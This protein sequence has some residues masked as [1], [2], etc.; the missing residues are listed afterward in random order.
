MDKKPLRQG[1]GSKPGDNRRGIK[2][3]GFIALIVL[4]GLIIFAAYNQPSNLQKIPITTAVQDANA[5]KYDKIVVNGSELDITK[6]GAS[7]A[8]LKTYL[9]QNATLKDEGFNFSKVQI[10]TSPATSGS[11]TWVT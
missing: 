2:N 1:R 7:Q 4:F 6:K 3:A 11:S 9:E 10:D 8:T 5:G